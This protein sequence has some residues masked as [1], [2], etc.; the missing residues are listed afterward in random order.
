MI[1]YLHGLH[2]INHRFIGASVSNLHPIQATSLSAIWLITLYHSANGAI[3]SG[4]NRL[5]NT[6]ATLP[7]Q[8]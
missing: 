1:Y 8:K 5:Y 3:D 4:D 6:S 7:Q 2:E